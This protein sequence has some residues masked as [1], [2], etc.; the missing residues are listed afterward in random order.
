LMSSLP[1]R[2]HALKLPP[3]KLDFGLGHG[4]APP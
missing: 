3:R 4:H 2:R 1:Q